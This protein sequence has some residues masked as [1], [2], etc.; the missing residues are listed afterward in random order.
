MPKKDFTQIAFAVVQQATG[1]GLK[2]PPKPQKET[3]PKVT[4]GAVKRPSE[5]FKQVGAEQSTQAL[6]AHRIFLQFATHIQVVI[7]TILPF[8]K[9]DQFASA[10][11]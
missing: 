10:R 4:K 8:P 7:S 9:R 1:Q 2:Q 5:K 6:A 3:A 11:L